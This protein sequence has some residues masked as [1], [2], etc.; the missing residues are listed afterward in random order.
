MGEKKPLPIGKDDFRKIREGGFYY[1]DKTLMI[2][3][4]IAA[5]DEVTLITRPRRFGKT[6]SLTMMREFFDIGTDSKEIFNN[7]AI[8]ETEHAARINSIPVIYFAFKSVKG[9]TVEELTFQLKQALR[10]EYGR[11]EKLFHGKLGEMV[12]G[13]SFSE[14]FSVLMDRQAPYIYLSGAVSNL[15]KAVHEYYQIRPILLID[16]YDQ[17]IISS[18][19]YGYHDRLSG[20][21]SNF[22]GDAMKSNPALGQALLT[23][24]QRLAKESIFSQFNNVRVYTVLDEKYAPYFGLTEAETEKTLKDYDLVLDETVQK[25][26]NGYRFGGILMYNPWSVLNYADIKILR[27]YWINTSS[28]F[29]IKQTLKNANKEFWDDFDRLAA[30]E[31]VPI[32]LT[33]ET[34]YLERND[35]FTFWGLFVNSGY[36]TAL[37]WVH[38]KSAVVKIPNDEV[39]SEFQGMVASIAGIRGTDL[40]KMFESLVNKNMEKFLEIYQNIVISC[41]SYMDASE[42]AYHMLFLGMCI[43]LRGAYKVSSNLESGYG[44]S[45]IILEA[46]NAN[47]AHVII[48]FKQGKDLQRLKAEALEQILEQKYAA[49]LKGEVICIGLAHD[50][51]R[52]AMVYKT[53]TQ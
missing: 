28:N 14:T 32:W 41:T 5:K 20:F 11:Y 15:I 26:Y 13:K 51:K 31:E 43:T 27:N 25:K 3:D 48:E 42:N 1:I 45:D 34:S 33:L 17:P 9:T 37:K 44:R 50:K 18:F 23:G 30:G 22:Y 10:D 8:M 19:E 40:E 7:L 12:S 29:L 6:L 49:H 39:M 2:Q 36:L 52:C 35:N 53:I 47:Y 46:L 16:E 24:V 21:F 38:E 4:F